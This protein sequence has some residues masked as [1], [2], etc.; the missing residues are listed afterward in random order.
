MARRRIGQ[1]DLIARPEPRSASSLAE[2]AA[3][4]D[5]AEIDRALVGISAAAKGEPGWPPLALFRGLLLATWHDLSD[6][7][8]AEALDDRAHLEAQLRP[9]ADALARPGQG[10]PAGPSRRHGLQPSAHGHPA[11]LCGR[12]MRDESVRITP[13]GPVRR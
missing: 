11:E 3:L 1:E 6:I 4:L 8:M 9:A 13:N 2:L 12:M 10:R 5:W 7:R